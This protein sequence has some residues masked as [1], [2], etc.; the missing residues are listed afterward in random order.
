MITR[1][2]EHPHAMAMAL[3]GALKAIPASR[4]E[5][6]RSRASLEITLDGDPL[7]AMGLGASPTRWCATCGSGFRLVTSWEAAATADVSFRTLYR[8]AE[9]EE[10]HYSVTNEGTLFV[11][12]DSLLERTWAQN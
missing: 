1:Q 7:R 6:K 3:V 12:L 10:I 8:W 5:A 2:V 4:P 11:C 9:T